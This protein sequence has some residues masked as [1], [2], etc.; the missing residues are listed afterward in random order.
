MTT[1]RLA[2]PALVAMLG[3]GLVLEPNINAEAVAADVVVVVSKRSPVTSLSRSQV[4]DIFLG[5]TN[6][7]PD[8]E[9]AVPI[10]LDEGSSVRDSFY[11]TVADRSPSQVKAIWSKIIFT[12]RGMPPDVAAN[13]ALVK[14]RLGENPHAIGYLESNQVDSTVHVVTTR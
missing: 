2:K 11:A 1:N 9:Q 3:L 8:G 5:R 4:A 10:D 12:G 6:R 7:F 13:A 14:Q